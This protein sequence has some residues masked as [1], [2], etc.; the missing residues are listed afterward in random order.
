MLLTIFRI[1]KITINLSSRLQSKL[2][3]EKWSY[4]YYCV[5]YKVKEQKYQKDLRKIKIIKYKTKIY[6]LS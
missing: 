1:F 6:M 3:R 2:I 4:F 5:R